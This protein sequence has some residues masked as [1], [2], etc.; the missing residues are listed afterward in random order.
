MAEESQGGRGKWIRLGLLAYE[1]EDR[2]FSRADAQVWFLEAAAEVQP[3]ILDD[4]AGEPLQVYKEVLRV[5]LDSA[6]DFLPSDPGDLKDYAATWEAVDYMDRWATWEDFLSELHTFIQRGWDIDHGSLKVSIER[7][8]GR[9]NLG[10]VDWVKTTGLRTLAAWAVVP[11]M[12]RGWRHGET[13]VVDVIQPEKHP[14]QLMTQGWDPTLETRDQAKRR[15]RRA[16]EER[17]AAHLEEIEGQVPVSGFVLTPTKRGGDDHWR[18]LAQ[19]V[20]LRWTYE[21]IADEAGNQRE[22]TLD[23]ASVYQ[24]VSKAAAL[25]GLPLPKGK[26]GPRPKADSDPS[27]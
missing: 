7:W 17:L 21:R 13:P 6:R 14:F 1:P 5:R 8:A 15:I 3:Q 27:R 24:A 20:I 12:P 23:I 16:F 26:P 11:S 25:A 18:W 19:Q 4:L 10:E 9:W 2:P 22:D